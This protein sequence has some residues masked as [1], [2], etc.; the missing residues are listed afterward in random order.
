MFDEDAYWDRF[1][2]DLYDRLG[3]AR[4][5]WFPAGLSAHRGVERLLPNHY[6]DLHDWSVRRHWPGAEITVANNPMDIVEELVALIHTQLSALS[7]GP[8]EI[9]QA[10]TAGRETRM[11][12][13]CA[14]PVVEQTLF[15]TVAGPDRHEC[16][17]RMAR[18]IA[19]DLGLRHR[20]V[21]RVEASPAQ[22]ELFVRRGGH[23]VGDTNA[24][25]HPSVWPLAEKHVLVGGLGGEIG[26][27]FLW[28]A[29]DTPDMTVSTSRIIGRLG[30]PKLDALTTRI[31][32]WLAGLPRDLTGGNAFSVLDL[33]YIEQRMGPWYG[34][35]FYC[36][37]TLVRLAPLMTRRAVELMLSL[38]PDWKR[39]S[40]LYDEIIARNWPELGHYPY[41]SLG[42][43]RDGINKARKAIQNPRIILKKLRKLA[44]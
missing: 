13:A 28:Q 3:V 14:R 18:R 7:R 15:T 41:N 12:L 16:D 6:L 17:T 2:R 35:Q 8:K 21:A 38:P 43:W 4:E 22:R 5:G 27:A 44:Q 25:Y 36:D 9:A 23:C 40:R 33:A 34:V 39:S 26:R 42:V 31:D 20:E 29:S 19:G 24:L 11:L 10:L 30:L 32:A 1:D 37:P